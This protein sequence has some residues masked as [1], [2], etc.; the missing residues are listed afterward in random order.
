MRANESEPGKAEGNPLGHFLKYSWVPV[1]VPP[2][3]MLV[4]WQCWVHSS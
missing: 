1:T 3:D 2:G 4:L